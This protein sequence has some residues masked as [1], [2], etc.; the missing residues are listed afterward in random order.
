M[1][2]HPFESIINSMIF[3]DLC[4][5]FYLSIDIFVHPNDRDMGLCIKLHASVDILINVN[6]YDSIMNHLDK[7][8][9]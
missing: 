3:E 9:C 8:A 4:T 7:S 2:G 6:I 5:V 1:T